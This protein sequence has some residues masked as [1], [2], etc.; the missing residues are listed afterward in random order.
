MLGSMQGLDHRGRTPEPTQ[1]ENW[2]KIRLKR[3]CQTIM[4]GGSLRWLAADGKQVA[5]INNAESLR[6]Q[7]SKAYMR[8]PWKNS[9]IL[10][11]RKTTLMQ[12]REVLI[13]A[14]RPLG[15]VTKVQ[16]RF[17]VPKIH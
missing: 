7:I 14:E 13:S 16:R 8:R 11:G 5:I 17:F 3:I 1:Y 15:F 2:R 10:V 12:N 9:P 4:R 6:V